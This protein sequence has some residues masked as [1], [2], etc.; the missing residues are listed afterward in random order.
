MRFLVKKIEIFSW[1]FLFIVSLFICINNIDKQA[2]ADEDEDIFAE[3]DAITVN[4]HANEYDPWEKFNRKIFAFNGLLSYYV[5]IPFSDWYEKKL[6]IQVRWTFKNYMQ[7]YTENATDILYSTLD[8]DLEAI[9]VSF[10]RFTLNTLFGMFGGDD[11]AYL[12]NL[13]PYRKSIGNILQFYHIPRGPFLILPILGSTNLRDGIGTLAG[14]LLTTSWITK[15]LLLDWFKLFY[16]QYTFSPFYIPFHKTSD[17][18]WTSF[19]WGIGLY[20]HKFSEQGK[21]ASTLDFN[22][23]DIYIDA[24]TQ[25]YQMLDKT[26]KKYIDLRMNGTTTRTNVCDYDAMVE[27]PEECYEDPKTYGIGVEKFKEITY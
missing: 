27:L 5:L 13:Q 11:V 18:V 12:V 10:W 9:A 26:E 8:F 20:I 6:P 24:R 3:A 21:M 17:L 16:Y 25:Y 22:S 14:F 4:L 19:G 1:L 23:K 7:N 15:P 2:F